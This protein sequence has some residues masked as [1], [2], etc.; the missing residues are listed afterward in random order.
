MGRTVGLGIG[1]GGW[2]WK[3]KTVYWVLLYCLVAI[4]GG[5]WWPLEGDLYRDGLPLA[6]LVADV[7]M[8]GLTCGLCMEARTSSTLEEWN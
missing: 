8:Y 4:F 3:V 1:L 2:V 7:F 5:S 6:A